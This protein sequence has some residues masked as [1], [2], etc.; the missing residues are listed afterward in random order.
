MI[1]LLLFKNTHQLPPAGN[2]RG[3]GDETAQMY[4]IRAN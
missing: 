3:T 4:K 1:F 2:E